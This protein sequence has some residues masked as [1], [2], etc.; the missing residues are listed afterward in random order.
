M[1]AADGELWWRRRVPGG[2]AGWPGGERR[3]VGPSSGGDGAV[4]WREAQGGRE[5]W[6]RWRSPMEAA[7]GG[8]ELRQGR[9]S[10]VEAALLGSCGRTS[11]D[12]GSTPGESDSE[13]IRI[14]GR[15]L[16]RGGV[17]R[18]AHQVTSWSTADG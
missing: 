1:A 6:R 2:R 16:I 12:R 8:R 11:S 18:G 9:R 15:T 14:E 7:Q 5:L 13:S 10:L 3:R 17:M 4:W